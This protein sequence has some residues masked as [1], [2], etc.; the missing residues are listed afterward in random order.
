[1]PAPTSVSG[2]GPVPAAVSGSGSAPAPIGLAEGLVINSR[3][4]LDAK[5]GQGG[6]GAVWRATDL[7]L[8]EVVAM[9]F[10]T[11]VAAD[12]GLLQRFKQEVTLSRQFNHPNIIR[13]HDLGTWGEHKYITME[14]LQGRDL[15]KVMTGTP[16]DIDK[17]LGYLVQA[18]SAL[19]AV[20]DRGVIHRDIK[21]ENFFVSDDGVVKV[22]DFGI[23]KRRNA[24]K[25]L[26]RAGMMAGTPQ[27]MAPEQINDFGSVN[28]LADVYS[29]GII[30]YQIFTGDV[31][32]DN[33]ELMPI[34]VAHLTQAPAAPAEKNPKIPP[35]LDAVILK[36]L[37]KKPAERVQSCREVA[38]DLARIRM[39]LAVP[40][41]S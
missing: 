7:E 2:S 3:Y 27:Y 40:R 10:L 5:I 39:Q 31:P 32:F 16:L 22:M 38:G 34:L 13:L 17:G 9:K 35:E 29:I 6:M 21:P 12:E 15:S 30:A 14:L 1:M 23:A 8:D 41:R 36:L 28:H 37:A 25:G 33:E 19:Q 20:H 24:A 4:R 18:C 11:A 26:T